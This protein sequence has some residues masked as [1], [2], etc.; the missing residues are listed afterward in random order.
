MAVV[1]FPPVE[2]ADQDGLLA[3]GGD[4]EVPTL[5]LAYSRGIFPWPIDEGHPLAWFSPDPRGVLFYKNLNISRSLQKFRKRELYRF[6]F[7][8]NF[9]E[10]ILKCSDVKNRKGQDK[11]WITNDIIKSY[12]D[13]FNAGFAYSAEAYDKD[14]QLVGG[15][16]GVK[17]GHYFSGESMFYRKTNAGKLALIHLMET[18]YDNGIEWLDVQ[19][20]SPVVKNIGGKMI[21]REEFLKR[22]DTSIKN[23]S[24]VNF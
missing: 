9:E 1:D 23:R 21:A 20:L 2:L 14:D 13:L 24:R 10:V 16:Y 4:L 8:E 6:G 11:T 22:L 19:T 5:L 15:L 17:I 12:I 7:N 3:I 18:L